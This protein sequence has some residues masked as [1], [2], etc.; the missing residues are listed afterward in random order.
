MKIAHLI[1]AHNNPKQLEL[2]ISRL[3]YADDAVYIH[4]DKKARLEDFIY[5]KTLKNVFFINNRVSVHWGASSMTDA[6]LNGFAEIIASGLKFDFVNLLSGCDYPLQTPDYIHEF[7]RQNQGKIFMSYKVF[8]DDWQEAESRIH[9][10]HLNAYQFPGC[11][12]LQDVLNRITPKRTLPDAMIAVGRSQWFTASAESVAYILDYWQKH[13]RF[14]RFIKFT[15]GPDEFLFQ[16]ILYNSPYR[17]LMVNTNLRYIDW[18]AGGA[19]PK[20]L[21]L[22]D[23]EKLLASKKLYARK[24]DLNKHSDIIYAIDQKLDSS[25]SLASA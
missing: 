16:T 8:S 20:T 23:T 11:F 14:R 2:L 3:L 24:F 12:K 15:W 17:E 1:L 22:S 25:T 5:L 4:L 7:L 10:Y 21:T 18:S 19:S 6:T 9:Q 13:A